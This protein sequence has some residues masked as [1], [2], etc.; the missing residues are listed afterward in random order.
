MNNKFQNDKFGRTQR[1]SLPLIVRSS[2]IAVKN[3][4]WF[5]LLTKHLPWASSDI[6]M[7]FVSSISFK[8]GSIPYEVSGTRYTLLSVILNIHSTVAHQIVHEEDPS[9]IWCCG[10][11]L[12]KLYPTC[13]I[14]ICCYPRLWHSL[15][16]FHG[17]ISFIHFPLSCHFTERVSSL[18]IMLDAVTQIRS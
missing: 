16:R 2:R 6:K 3:Y 9:Q 11:P 5:D 7:A 14:L 10:W 1:V 4:F 12:A 18:V 15:I 17:I 8:G 13:I